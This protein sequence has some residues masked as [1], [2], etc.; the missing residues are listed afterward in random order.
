MIKR[1]IWGKDRR[2]SVLSRDRVCGFLRVP[3][4]VLATPDELDAR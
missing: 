3:E 2:D 4:K 1:L